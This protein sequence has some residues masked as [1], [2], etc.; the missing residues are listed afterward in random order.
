MPKAL[1]IK[2]GRSPGCLFDVT[3]SALAA[4]ALTSQCHFDNGKH[5]G[6]VLGP[7]YLDGLTSP[8]TRSQPLF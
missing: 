8:G 2:I 5:P 7:S 4:T 3:E 6:G 1:Q